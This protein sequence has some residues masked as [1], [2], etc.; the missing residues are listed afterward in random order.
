M[1]L[2]LERFEKQSLGNNRITVLVLAVR[3]RTSIV[4]NCYGGC[5]LCCVLKL[6]QHRKQEK[7]KKIIQCNTC[8]A[9]NFKYIGSMFYEGHRTVNQMEGGRG[10]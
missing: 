7:W 3:N 10:V 8:H 5:F 6:K 1:D 9:C 4:D 2:G